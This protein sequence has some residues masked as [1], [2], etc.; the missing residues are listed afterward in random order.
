MPCIR[1]ANPKNPN[2]SE[3]L[4][5]KNTGNKKV[6]IP[7]HR[8][9]FSNSTE[10][11]LKSWYLQVYFVPYTDGNSVAPEQSWRKRSPT[12]PKSM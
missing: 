1:H 9:S 3:V 10:Q 7:L 8:A 4:T 12:N 11:I 5:S 6:T 2:I